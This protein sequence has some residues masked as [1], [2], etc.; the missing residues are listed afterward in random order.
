MRLQ[1]STRR[2]MSAL[3]SIRQKDCQP[4]IKELRRPG[5]R[6]GGEDALGKRLESG[7]DPRLERLANLGVVVVDERNSVDGLIL[8]ERSVPDLSDV[9]VCSSV[10]GLTGFARGR[11]LV[12]LE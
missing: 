2:R 4:N 8:D 6:K 5:K 1:P 10:S 7:V 3:E 9:K 12:S 11:R